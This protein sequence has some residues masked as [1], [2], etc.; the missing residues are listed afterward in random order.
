ML[1]AGVD[2]EG[3]HH[4]LNSSGGQRMF[5]PLLLSKLYQIAIIKSRD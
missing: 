2:K 3:G 4:S 5:L 1:K